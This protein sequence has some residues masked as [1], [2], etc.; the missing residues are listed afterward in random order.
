[1]VNV[2]LEDGQSLV[3]EMPAEDVASSSLK[4]A[5]QAMS[6]KGR[7]VI[8]CLPIPLMGHGTQHQFI[9]I[10]SSLPKGV[11]WENFAPLSWSPL[12]YTSASP[13]F[14][15]SILFHRRR[16]QHG[17]QSHRFRRLPLRR[18]R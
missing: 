7:R 5:D 15:I 9:S 13:W 16:P 6:A 2:Q 14:R 8:G 17:L 4:K 11:P 1:V 18:L 3:E 10:L 12:T